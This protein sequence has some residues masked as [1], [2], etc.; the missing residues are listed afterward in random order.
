MVK[1]IDE[2]ARATAA[3]LSKR[4]D[5]VAM[6]NLSKEDDTSGFLS[7]KPFTTLV[8]SAS[9]HSFFEGEIWIRLRTFNRGEA[10]ESLGIQLSDQ[11]TVKGLNRFYVGPIIRRENNLVEPIANR[12]IKDPS[13]QAGVLNLLKFFNSRDDDSLVW[14]TKHVFS[15]ESPSLTTLDR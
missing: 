7:L 13:D 2:E 6:V 9:A 5:D 8:A 11:G 3:T 1:S 15:I 4:L 12:E 10:M 14:M